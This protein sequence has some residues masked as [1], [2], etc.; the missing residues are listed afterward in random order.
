M[1]PGSGIVFF[2]ENQDIFDQYPLYLAAGN[3]ECGGDSNGLGWVDP[4]LS[5]EPVDSTA[6][7]LLGRYNPPQNGAAYYGAGSNGDQPLTTGHAQMEAMAGNYYFIYDDTLFMVVDYQDHT[8][9]ELVKAE[10]QWVESVVKS[11]P[12]VQW[13]IAVMHES[14]FGYRVTDPTT[15]MN[16][17]W[18]DTFDKAGVTVK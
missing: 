16:G 7:A 13:R 15:G 18:T 11:H 10:Q 8:D 3:H 5:G 17:D 6:S 4:S 2:E 12:E 14:L 1:T 9:D